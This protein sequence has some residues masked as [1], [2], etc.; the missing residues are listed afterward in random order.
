M[1][2]RIMQLLVENNNAVF[3]QTKD[4]TVAIENTPSKNGILS[5]LEETV[6]V[7]TILAGASNVKE[8]IKENA[9]DVPKNNT[10][11]NVNDFLI[12]HIDAVDRNTI[13]DDNDSI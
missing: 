9:S 5:N 4:Q 2:K 10:P 11:E 13:A 3:W 1:K 6:S 12:D 7:N 8:D